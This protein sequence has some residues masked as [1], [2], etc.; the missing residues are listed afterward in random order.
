MKL[1]E[2]CP[3]ILK[4]KCISDEMFPPMLVICVVRTKKINSEWFTKLNNY[5]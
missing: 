5:F 4:I 2:S 1:K 3:F